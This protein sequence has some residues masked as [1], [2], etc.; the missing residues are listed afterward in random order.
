M[1][2]RSVVLLAACVA[3]ARLLGCWVIRDKEKD[4]ERWDAVELTSLPHALLPPA[5]HEPLGCR[6]NGGLG[7][8][9]HES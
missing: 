4:P 9:P 5:G 1:A 2:P 8:P 3:C 6:V 7:A